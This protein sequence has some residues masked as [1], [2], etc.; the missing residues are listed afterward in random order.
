[1]RATRSISS[2]DCSIRFSWAIADSYS[3]L[4]LTRI[5]SHSKSSV[6]RLSRMISA[7]NGL[8]SRCSKRRCCFIEAISLLLDLFNR[9]FHKAAPPSRPW[10]TL[11]R[12]EAIS[13][14]FFAAKRQEAFLGLTKT[15][16]FEGYFFSGARVY[17]PQPLSCSLGFWIGGATSAWPSRP[18]LAER[19]GQG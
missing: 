8:S 2:S 17:D 16:L 3:C 9:L 10:E 15:G 4:V 12:R 7:S 1:M 11:F 6:L 19:P 5:C 13:I 18:T 14:P